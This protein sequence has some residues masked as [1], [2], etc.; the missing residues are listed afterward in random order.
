MAIDFSRASLPPIPY[1]RAPYSRFSSGLS[2]LKNAAS[3][4]TRLIMRLTS[5]SCRMMS[6]P[7][8]RTSPSSGISRVESRRTSV[9]LPEP[10]GPRMP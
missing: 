5:I 10:L 8:T 6:R 9:L 4:D 7:K 1:R 2:F 3:T